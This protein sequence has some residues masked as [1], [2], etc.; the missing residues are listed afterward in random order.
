MSDGSVEKTAISKKSNSQ[1]VRNV[2][3]KY[4]EK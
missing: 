1:I 2:I 3:N 4:E